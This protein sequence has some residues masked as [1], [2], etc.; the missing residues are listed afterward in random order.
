M[1]L[2]IRNSLIPIDEK[3]AEELE[4][5]SKLQIKNGNGV[6]A[7]LIGQQGEEITL[8]APLIEVLKEVAR[9]TQQQEIPQVGAFNGKLTVLQA[10]NIL[11]VAEKHI[12]ELLEANKIPYQESEHGQLIDYDDLIN[13]QNN[14]V[15]DRKE[16]MRRLIELEQELGLYEQ[17]V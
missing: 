13:Y 2:L 17:K 3:V 6:V 9:L 4:Q 11:Y 15:E 1:N 7:R 10:A 5:I 12:L 8:H 14:L 16:G